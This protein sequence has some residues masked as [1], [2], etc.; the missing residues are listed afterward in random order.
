MNLPEQAKAAGDVASVAVVVGTLAQ[1]L[2]AVA[3]TLTIIWTLLRIT[4][5]PRVQRHW[6]CFLRRFK[7]SK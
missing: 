3:A 1:W 5:D 7:R 4:E 2:P 6:E